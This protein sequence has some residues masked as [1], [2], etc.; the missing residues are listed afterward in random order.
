[1]KLL[2]QNS[3]LRRK[4]SDRLYF[5]AVDQIVGRIRS[6]RMQNGSDTRNESV[7]RR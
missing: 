6:N 7:G 2:L 5:D 3:R 4:H 1:M